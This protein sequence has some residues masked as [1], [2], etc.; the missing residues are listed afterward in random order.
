MA[1]T[2]PIADF[3]TCIRNAVRM[4]KESVTVP[5]STMKTA[6]AEIL[7]SRGYIADYTVVEEG[8]RKFIHMKLKYKHNGKP[9]IANIVRVSTP[10]LRRY[11][12]GTKVPKVLN[13]I[14]CV[15]ISTSQGIMTDNDARSKNIGGEVICKVW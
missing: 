8:I 15:I 14:G 1:I 4:Q 7:K 9:A 2:D 13:G 6:I 12:E 10:G 3:L 5:S 11:V